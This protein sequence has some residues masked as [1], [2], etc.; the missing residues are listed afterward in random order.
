[1]ISNF[2]YLLDLCGMD[3]SKVKLHFGLSFAEVSG[4]STIN[5][6][7]FL[8]SISGLTEGICAEVCRFLSLVL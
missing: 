7:F 4:L 8:H 1:M 6:N 5:P 3:W 2:A